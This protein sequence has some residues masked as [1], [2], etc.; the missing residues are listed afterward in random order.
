MKIF[1]LL[2]GI[3]Y[4]Y[5][6][7]YTP[8]LKDSSEKLNNNIIMQVTFYQ[9][10]ITF[11]NMADNRIFV[12]TNFSPVAFKSINYPIKCCLLCRGALDDLCHTCLEDGSENCPIV[13]V[14]GL[15][16]HQH[17]HQYIKKG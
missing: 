5:V 3:V 4:H 11:D 6:T 9:V 2:I 15:H 8:S 7:N 13:E 16:Y 14:E 17:C 12:L 10:V 1:L